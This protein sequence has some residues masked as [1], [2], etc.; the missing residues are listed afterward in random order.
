MLADLNWTDR[1]LLKRVRMPLLPKQV[2]HATHSGAFRGQSTSAGSSS[3][4]EV[5]LIINTSNTTITPSSSSFQNFVIDRPNITGRYADPTNNFICSWSDEP[6]FAATDRL[7]STDLVKTGS[8]GFVTFY[9]F[10]ARHAE[11]GSTD[12]Y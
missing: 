8:G 3:A 1:D 4:S 10:K 12:H 7:V 11:L 5:E 2:R 6:V 9:V